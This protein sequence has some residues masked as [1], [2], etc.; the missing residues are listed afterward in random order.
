MDTTDRVAPENAKNGDTWTHPGDQIKKTYHNGEWVVTVPEVEAAAPA[1]D[2]PPAGGTDES[3]DEKAETEQQAAGKP[4]GEDDVEKLVRNRRR[5]NA[6][7]L[8]DEA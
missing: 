5:D 1:P 4:L 8:D 7:K 3:S 6:K 2:A